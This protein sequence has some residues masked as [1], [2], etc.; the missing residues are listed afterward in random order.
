MAR[1]MK[2]AE[3]AGT[4]PAA[5]RVRP[6]CFRKRRRVTRGDLRV[7]IF[8]SSYGCS[9]WTRLI[10]MGD[11]SWSGLDRVLFIATIAFKC[12]LQHFYLSRSLGTLAYREML[13]GKMRWM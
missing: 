12:A 11:Q 5:T 13:L 9:S 3:K 10:Q 8:S 4:E 1:E 6:V 7:L 2:G